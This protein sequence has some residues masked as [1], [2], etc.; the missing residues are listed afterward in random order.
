MVQELEYQLK[1]KHEHDEK[2]LEDYLT[3][4]YAKGKSLDAHLRLAKAKKKRSA[5]FDLSYPAGQSYPARDV[6]INADY[7]E[8]VCLLTS[9]WIGGFSFLLYSH[10]HTHARIH[11]HTRTHR[12]L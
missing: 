6:K 3:L 5:T 9:S 12:L 4:R 10:T 11:T 7:I 2:Q 8:K 1:G